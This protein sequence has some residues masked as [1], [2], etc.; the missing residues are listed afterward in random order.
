MHWSCHPENKFILFFKVVVTGSRY[1]I[2]TRLNFENKNCDPA[3]VRKPSNRIA[4]PYNVQKA[5]AMG[6]LR[7]LTDLK[8]TQRTENFH[9][10]NVDGTWA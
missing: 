7:V 10:I 1:R 4:G 6:D 8:N 3:P 9:K 5:L 2:E